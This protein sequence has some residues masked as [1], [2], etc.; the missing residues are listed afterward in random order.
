MAVRQP[1]VSVLGHVDHGKT[2]FLDYIRGTS[3]VDREAGAIT[4]HIGATEIPLDTIANICGELVDTSKF[5]IPGLLFIDTPGHHSFTTLRSRGGALADLAV[6]IVDITEGMKP[7]TLESIKILKRFQTPFIVGANKIDRIHG[8][9]DH[10]NECFMNSL[11]DQNERVQD[12]L[13]ELLYDFI[14]VLY[15][16]GFPAERYDRVKD[17]TKNM[18]IVPMS[19]KT[20]EG[21]A[22]MLML[23]VGLAQKFLEKRI[24]MEE[25]PGEGTVLEVKEEKGLGTTLDTIIYKGTV[26]QADTIVI[27]SQPPII[28]KV[29]AILKPKPND[30]IRDPR[31]RF[32]KVKEVSAA[33]GVKIA[34][35]DL[36]GVVGGA[37]LRV[38]N[39]AT[40]DEVIEDIAK[41]SKAEIEIADE[42]GITVKADAIGSLEALAFEL[43]GKGIKIKKAEVGNISRKDIVEICTAP[44]QLDRIILGF[45]V[46]MLPDAEEEVFTQSAKVVISNIV[47][48]LVDDYVEWYEK[49]KFDMERDDRGEITY[50][51]KFK[52]L[53]DCI[54]RVSKPAVC[55]VR[56]LGGRLRSGQ[57]VMRYDGRV[58]GRIKS[59]QSDG[60]T[61]NEA[62]Q[63]Q[64]VAISLE[65]VTIGR[66]IDVEDVAYVDI[67]EMDAK[68]LGDR[69]LSVDDQAILEEIFKIKRKDDKFWGM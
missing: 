63:G 46:S 13:D 10:K 65:A 14:A 47:Y 25:G 55:G 21:V 35:T 30:E 23:L 32:S 57:K 50:P 41:E 33:A 51:G 20:G 2:T 8:W 5:S 36:V 12:K 16:K 9:R 40:L 19:A 18:G 64:E 58:I 62:I 54:F 39:A 34:A 1:I 24:E 17:F 66:Q 28:S 15:K 6:L 42:G 45:N 27:G 29:K 11:Q 56:V 37:P 69:D 61:V 26:R 67:P 44:N 4:Q 22:D 60:K 3:V 68:A 43:K 59:I 31:E 7:Q 48:K 53:P 52:L 38:A 49:T